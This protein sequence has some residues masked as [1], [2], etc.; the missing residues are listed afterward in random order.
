MFCI[1]CLLCLFKMIMIFCFFFFMYTA[2]T[3][4]YTYLHTLSLHDALPISCASSSASLT[5]S[6][7]RS[8]IASTSTDADD[9]TSSWRVF[10]PSPSASTTRLLVMTCARWLP[11]S[12]YLCGAWRSEERRVGQEYVST[13]R[14]RCCPA[15][16]K[17]KQTYHNQHI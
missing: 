15:H 3:E 2:T 17:K 13:C 10:A 12:P 6:A 8:R 5:C 9:R 11:S 7:H 4:I 14:V 1:V 16:Q